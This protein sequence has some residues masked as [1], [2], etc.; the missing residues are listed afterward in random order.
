MGYFDAAK[1][2]PDRGKSCYAEDEE[3][4]AF[5]QADYL[6]IDPSGRIEPSSITINSLTNLH[7]TLPTGW[8]W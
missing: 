6:A 2:W 1:E 3:Y 4:M 5:L 8:D 7:S